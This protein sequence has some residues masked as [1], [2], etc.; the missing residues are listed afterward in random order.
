MHA[1]RAR[2]L[3]QVEAVRL[4]PGGAV[5]DRRQPGVARFERTRDDLVGAAVSPHRVDRDADH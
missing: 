1:D 5:E 3:V 2:R 4:G